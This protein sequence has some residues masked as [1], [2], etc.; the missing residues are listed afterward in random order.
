MERLK[1]NEPR[2]IAGAQEM[3]E[4]MIPLRADPA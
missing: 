3:A 1:K 4:T 2:T